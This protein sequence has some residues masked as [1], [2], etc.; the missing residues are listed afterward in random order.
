MYDLNS[1]FRMA[2]QSNAKFLKTWNNSDKF[3]WA[4][5]CFD[6]SDQIAISFRDSPMI[7]HEVIDVFIKIDNSSGNDTLEYKGDLIISHKIKNNGKVEKN[8]WKFKF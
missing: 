7:T 2:V 3:G 1:E 4:Y 6:E 8:F 5:S